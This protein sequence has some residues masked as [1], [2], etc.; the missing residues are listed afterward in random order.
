MDRLPT[1]V[2]LGFPCGSDGKESTCPVG[3]LGSI[4]GFGRFP[5][6]GKGYPLQN[7]G[8]ENSINH[9]VHGVAK[10]ST[11][12]TAFHFH[13]HCE[14]RASQVTLVA[15]NLPANAGDIRDAA[16]I[17]GSGRSTG[18][19]NGNPLQY[20]C[21]ENPKDRGAWQ[22]TVHGVTKSWTWLK[23][24]STQVV[25]MSSLYEQRQIEILLHFLLI[26]YSEHAS[27][28]ETSKI[29]CLC[30]FT[31]R[32]MYFVELTFPAKYSLLYLT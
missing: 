9:I 28:K 26:C 24:F 12:L 21:L 4:P 20:F 17:L 8:L 27:W 31:N 15:K 7:S 6:E 11:Q 32:S 5:G 2:F 3:G 25:S 1:P 29:L 18:G 10:R 16:S 22:A 30:V 19:G 23:Q 13:F 14:N